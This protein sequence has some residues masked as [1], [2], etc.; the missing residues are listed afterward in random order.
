MNILCT[1]SSGFICS[2][3][4]ERLKQDQRNNVQGFD[5]ARGQDLRNMSQVRDAVRNKD[6]VFHLAAVADLNWAR[7]HPNETE[8]INVKGTWNVAMAC[9][10][11]KARLFFASTI[12]VYGNQDVHPVTEESLP[13]PAEIYAATKLAGENLIKGVHHTYGLDYNFMRFAT[14]YGPGTRPALAT[15][16][17]LGQALRGEPITVHG[18]GLQTRTL[19]YID[20]LIDGIVYLWESGK[21]NDAWNLTTKEEVSAIQM[22]EDIKAVTQSKSPIIYIPQRI[23]Q[24]YRES[25]SAQ[26]MQHE[27]GWEAGVKWA[28]GI[29]RMAKWFVDTKQVEKIY[30]MPEK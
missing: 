18:H 3:L 26:K 16:I 27:T 9:H 13:R 1:G 20:D 7:V 17:F 15:H 24:T 21:M 10:E 5:I 29:N 22:A 11:I 19:T 25:I 14:I 2:K 8:A 23:G 30:R 4:V 6:V 12:C 28:D